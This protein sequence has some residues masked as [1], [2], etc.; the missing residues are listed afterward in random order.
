M[1]ASVRGLRSAALAL[2]V[3]VQAAC[4]PKP[5]R[6]DINPLEVT[7]Q[8]K[9]DAPTLAAKV[10]DR[11]GREVPGQTLS[12]ATSAPN[13][14]QVDGSGKLTAVEN[15]V[16]TVTASSGALAQ[17]VSVT[18]SIENPIEAMIG[19]IKAIFT[20]I[21]EHSQDC[22]KAAQAVTNYVTENR[23]ALRVLQKRAKE[24]E[25]RL[26]PEEKAELEEKVKADMMSFMQDSMAVMMEIGQR[27]P[28]QMKQIGEAMEAMSEK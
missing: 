3:L 23:S 27:C 2:A 25:A 8:N 4:A 19:H 13:I 26:G 9:V 15:G 6:I 1:K 28:E 17:T 18:V 21:K 5:A 7:I 22:D 14:V 12:F 20:L 16:A 10:V 11:D 24:M